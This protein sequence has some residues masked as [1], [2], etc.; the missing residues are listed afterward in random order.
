M[1]DETLAR[2]RPSVCGEKSVEATADKEPQ[3]AP[4]SMSANFLF[5]ETTDLL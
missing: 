2:Q 1:G 3:D 5:L 4:V